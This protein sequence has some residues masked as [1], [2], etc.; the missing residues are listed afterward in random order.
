MSFLDKV[1]GYVAK[2]EVPQYFLALNI[3]KD[4]VDAVIWGVVGG[5]TET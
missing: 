5:K 3:G 2:R 1:K 4:Q